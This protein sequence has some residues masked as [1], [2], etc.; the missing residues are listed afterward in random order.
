VITVILGIIG[1]LIGSFGNVVIYRLPAKKSVVWPGSSCPKCGHKIKS[2]E[3]IPIL[4]WLFLRGKCSNCKNPISVRYPLIEALTAAGFVVLALRFPLESYGFTVFPLL[5]IFAMLVMMS[6]IDIDH[7]ILPDS[8]TLP[9]LMVGILGTFIYAPESG[10]P[11]LMPALT[12]GAIGA[13][14]IALINRVGSLVLRRFADTKERLWPIGMDQVNVAAVGGAL[15]GWWV[16]LGVAAASFV[17]NL[18][19]RKP[20]R[21]PEQFLYAFWVIALVFSV[22]NLIIHPVQSIAGSLAAAGIMSIVGA[23]FWWLRDIFSKQEDASPEEDD[24]PVAMG[25]GDV[26]LAAVLGVLLGWQSLL[27][28]L[29]LSFV[30]GAVGGVIGR[31]FGGS[32]MV[33]FGPYLAIGGL[34]ALFVGQPLIEWY[35]GMLGL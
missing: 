32:R 9:A 34:L 30:I 14:I 22:T 11:T 8:L 27:V 24:E 15:G 28:A 2:W 33:P 17:A 6:M 23:T 26:K 21:I 5:A 12:G 13:G 4:S 35:L 19:T 1:A 7:Y 29:L 18:V 10:L 20:V 16:G 31:L 25:F 3:N